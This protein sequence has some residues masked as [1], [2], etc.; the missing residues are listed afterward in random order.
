MTERQ[1]ETAVLVMSDLHYGKH[2]ASYTVDV[3]P[4]RLEAISRR[5]ARLHELLTGQYDIDALRIMCLGDVNDGTEIYKTQAHHQRLS[6][7]EEQ[8][9][10]LTDNLA[11]FLAQQKDVWGHVEI[12]TVPGNHGRSG[13]FAHEAASW[14]IVS[15][16]YLGHKVAHLD[17][18]VTIDKRDPFLRVVRIRGHRYLLYHGHGI[19]MYQG[20]PWYGIQQRLMR[21][22]TTKRLSGFDVAMFGHFHYSGTMPINRIHTM[23]TGT[24]ITDDEWALQELGWE[25]VN[26]WHLFGVSDK[27]PVTWHFDVDTA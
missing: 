22:N 2:T 13:L 10:Y 8:A 12:D 20:I 19:R 1:R 25:S 23:L 9:E 16:R 4:K 18:P 15:Y 21:W 6:N 14:D 11:V 5:L 17:I 3:F 26:S 27:R 24:M 7:V